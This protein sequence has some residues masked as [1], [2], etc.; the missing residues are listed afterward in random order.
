MSIEPFNSKTLKKEKEDEF[1]LAN[2]NLNDREKDLLRK[3]WNY[4]C[5][6]KAAKVCRRA[7][8]S[9]YKTVCDSHKCSSS[10]KR[11]FKRKCRSNCNDRFNSNNKRDDTDSE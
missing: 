5:N 9:T 10:M 7:C 6:K 4:S 8:I 2:L 11:K 3:S 1:P